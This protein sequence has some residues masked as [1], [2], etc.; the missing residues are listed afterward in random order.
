MPYSFENAMI[1]I[2]EECG[3]TETVVRSYHGSLVSIARRNGW[4]LGPI[5]RSWCSAE[6]CEKRPRKN[7]NAEYG[8]KTE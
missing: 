7:P 2:C 3:E 4:I 6:C 1:L 5:R 8:M